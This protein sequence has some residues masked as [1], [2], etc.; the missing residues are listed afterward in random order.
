MG[1]QVISHAA[2]RG[3]LPS[4]K[5]LM[6]GALCALL[7]LLVQFTAVQLCG[8]HYAVGIVL[9]FLILV[10][11]S[12]FIHKNVTFRTEGK[13]SWRR[14]TLY[15]TQWTVLL[16]LNI[17]LMALC[18]DL[19]DMPYNPAMVLVAGIGT[20]LSYGYSR[21]YVFQQASAAK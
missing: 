19:L 17:L 13:L 9:S 21:S 10:P 4:L 12:F 16:V 7:N 20:V 3:R 1:T 5:Y 18:V 11:L 6:V 14:F 15:A 8:A 2:L